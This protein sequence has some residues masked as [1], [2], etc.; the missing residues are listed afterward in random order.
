MFPDKR[1]GP[2]PQNK[3]DEL[4][5]ELKEKESESAEDEEERAN[6][7]R[8]AAEF[9]SKANINDR[10]ASILYGIPDSE[11]TDRDRETSL[12]YLRRMTHPTDER[13]FFSYSLKLELKKQTEENPFDIIENVPEESMFWSREAI[14]SAERRINEQ[15]LSIIKKNWAKQKKE[16]KKRIQRENGG[17]FN[18][19]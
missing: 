6:L 18:T 8:E 11:K 14:D 9:Y 16:F 1:G 10:A 4:K 12:E 7:L 3:L 19:N 17:Q 15:I 13:E 5:G 2:Y